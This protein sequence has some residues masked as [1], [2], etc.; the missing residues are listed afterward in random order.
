MKLYIG[1]FIGACFVYLIGSSIYTQIQKENKSARSS[2]ISCHKDATVFERLYIEKEK[3]AI[4]KKLEEGNYTLSSSVLKAVYSKS[5]LFDF[6]DLDYI[7]ENDVDDPGKKTAKSKLYAGYIVVKFKN[8]K[9]EL[10]YQV[11]VD[12]M[13]KK[14][15]DLPQ[16]IKCAIKSF[17]TI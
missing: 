5:K 7:Y 9:N 14:G 2:R 15:A 16:S 10:I 12:F 1:I 6:V 17:I 11:Q 8:D 4:Q 3:K 13:D